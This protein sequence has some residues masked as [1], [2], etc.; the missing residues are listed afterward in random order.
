MVGNTM[1]EYAAI[2]RVAVNTVALF[3][4]RPRISLLEHRGLSSGWNLRLSRKLLYVAHVTYVQS[5][6][7]SYGA[8]V[9]E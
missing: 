8:L 7:T 3:L 6:R 2:T 5:S 9:D 1:V 4:L